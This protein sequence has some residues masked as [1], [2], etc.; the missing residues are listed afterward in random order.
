MDT[1][2]FTMTVANCVTKPIDVWVER[3]EYNIDDRL[4][5][6]IILFYYETK[7]WRKTNFFFYELLQIIVRIDVFSAR[8]FIRLV[9]WSFVAF[10]CYRR[11]FCFANHSI[12]EKT[13]E[14]D[15]FIGFMLDKRA[16]CLQV[17]LPIIEI[18]V[19]FAHF[20]FCTI[21]LVC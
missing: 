13:T 9:I 5:Y 16:L 17:T 21:F 7:W 11:I 18:I 1:R 2:L 3:W 15:L 8:P 6:V 4:T 10:L 14:R 12:M 20:C 19:A